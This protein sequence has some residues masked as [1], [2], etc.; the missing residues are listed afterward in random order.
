MAYRFDSE[1]DAIQENKTGS[2][3]GKG[4]DEIVYRVEER[5]L[6][7]Y[8]PGLQLWV[9]GHLFGLSAV[10]KKIQWFRNWFIAQ[11]EPTELW[12]IQ[13]PFT[14]QIRFGYNAIESRSELFVKPNFYWN[15]FNKL[16]S[17]GAAFTYA[18]DFGESRL[19]GE[20]PFTYI[21]LEPKLQLNFQSSY[22]AFVYN[23]RQD[24]FHASQQLNAGF[25]PIKQTQY[26][27]LRFC[28]YY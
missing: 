27:N 17:V 5:V 19:E 22:I 2:D 8:V 25:D 28:I 18:Q 4:E 11:Y 21:E 3:A 9:F 12:G 1:L 24:Y 15:F 26:I 13:R 7:N 20:H 14:A 23:W 6:T 16:I 10:D